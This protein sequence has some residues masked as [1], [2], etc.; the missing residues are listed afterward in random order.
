MARSSAE[1]VA[2]TARPVDRAVGAYLLVS[3][4]ALAFPHRPALWAV[5]LLAHVGGAAVLFSGWPETVRADIGAGDGARG[6]AGRRVV[7]VLVDWY[8]LILLPAIYLEIQLLNSAV[9]DARYFDAVIMGWEDALFGGQPSV[10][11]ASRYDAVAV[12][13]LLHF[14]YL[15]FFPL[16]YLVP[17]WLYLTGRLQ[18][19]HET[20]FAVVLGFAVHYVV[21]I[22]FP[23]QGPRYLFPGPAGAPTEGALYGFTRTLLESGSSQGAAF[24]SS[25]VALAAIQ[26]GNAVRFAQKL[27]PLF[28]VL[29]LGIALGAVYGGFHYGVDASAGLLAGAA[30]AALAPR[31][32]RWLR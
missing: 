6:G 8:P 16:V 20:V 1:P 17:A 9:W 4:T 22:Y 10:E 2:G 14:A 31:F 24:P 23:V 3:A 28:G 15:M 32:W 18:A 13:E 7:G 27:A 25:H 30:I 19:F 29:T 26:T 11:L 5:L 12:S 21:F